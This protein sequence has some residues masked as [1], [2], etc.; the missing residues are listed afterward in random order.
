MFARLIALLATGEAAA[1]K[2]R[3]KTAA[4]F[5]LAAGFLGFLA[6]IFLVLAAYLA[7]ATRWGAIATAVW[8]GLGLLVLSAVIFIAYRISARSR[9]RAE[10][11]KRAESMM[12]GASAL[13]MLP[14]LVGKKRNWVTAVMVLAGLGG[15]LA[16]TELMRRSRRAED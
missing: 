2:R 3:I 1:V 9:R 15:Y 8:F 16:Y 4:I 10:M 13:A 14:S 7:A 5:Y 12:V 11:S 6:V